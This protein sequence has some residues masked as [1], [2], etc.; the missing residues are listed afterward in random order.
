M[1]SFLKF[2]KSE[3]ISVFFSAGIIYRLSVSWFLAPDN[4][5]Q[6]Q[7]PENGQCV[8]ELTVC[9]FSRYLHE[10]CM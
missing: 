7:A 5:R 9:H 3:H 1:S 6:K 4:W 2:S 10:G 8:I